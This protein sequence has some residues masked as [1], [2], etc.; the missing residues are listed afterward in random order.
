MENHVGEQKRLWLPS[1]KQGTVAL[2]LASLALIGVTLIH[3]FNN[4]LAQAPPEP[5]PEPTTPIIK[6]VTALGRIEP[7]G[8]VIQLAPAASIEGA[9]V[10]Q[11][12][13]GE[14]D[15]VEVGQVIAILDSRDRL[16]ATLELA[17]KEVK[18]AQANLAIVKAGAKQGEIFAQ[19]ATIESLQAQL[20]GEI[21]TQQATIARYEAELRNAQSEYRRYE[22]LERDGAI[23]ASD[24]DTRLLT[25]ETA[26]E[27]LRE[28]QA[29]R[30]RIVDTLKEQ[31]QAA[32][33]TL[34]RIA[35]VRPVEV[36]KAQA[37]VERAIAAVEQ[38]QA[39]LDVA[40]VKTP[41]DG[42]IIYINTHAGET[43]GN[44]GILDI[45]Y[46]NQMLVVAEVH[47]SDIGKVERGQQV[48]I[49]SESGSFTEE[50]Q[51][52]VDKIALQI[53]K[54]DV[55]DTDPA[56]DVDTRIVEVDILLTPESSRRVSSLTNTKVIVKILL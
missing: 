41:L 46:T 56:A 42:Q 48:N 51:G 50:L 25:L 53:H 15:R 43:V 14:G 7:Q 33:A 28:S 5:T 55:L 21:S 38:A 40:Y 26:R 11:L 8:E 4:H 3:T 1:A 31:I 12:L 34:D 23:S 47:E 49:S 9:K 16:Q 22:K 27:K 37:E 30:N 52:T 39:E 19:K 13:V 24:L 20:Q 18:V 45:G 6:A 54:N 44:E 29:T 35:E 17:Q 36:A 10:G 32:R 2:S